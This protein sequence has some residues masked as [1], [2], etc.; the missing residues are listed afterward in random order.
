MMRRHCM[1]ASTDLAAT[2]G[3]CIHAQRLRRHMRAGR[4]KV[5]QGLACMPVKPGV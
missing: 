3:K 1:K 2:Q 5:V 4:G